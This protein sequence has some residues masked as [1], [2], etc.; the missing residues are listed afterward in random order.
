MRV[1]LY[2]EE[3]HMSLIDI[4]LNMLYQ[5]GTIRS[6]ATLPKLKQYSENAARFTCQDFKRTLSVAAMLQKLQ[7]D[8]VQQRHARSLV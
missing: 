7:S 8:S 1:I 6:S 2:N 5:C 4:N 3:R